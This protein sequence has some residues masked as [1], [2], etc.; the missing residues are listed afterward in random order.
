MK[1]RQLAIVSVVLFGLG[2]GQENSPKHK[3]APAVEAA[4]QDTLRADQFEV[5]ARLREGGMDPKV[6]PA[7][8]VADSMIRAMDTLPEDPRGQRYLDVEK[9]RM[10]MVEFSTVAT[11]KQ[12]EAAYEDGFRFRNWYF[13]GMVTIET[14]RKMQQALGT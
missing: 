12:M 14:T 7:T 8:R 5:L 11:A 10:V 1:F 9:E 4:R 13:G 2:C 6:R 3:A